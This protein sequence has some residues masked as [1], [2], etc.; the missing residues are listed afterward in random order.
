ML[1]ESKATLCKPSGSLLPVSLP[2]F[3]KH[4]GIAFGLCKDFVSNP[5][6]IL[7]D[8]WNLTQGNAPEACL[9]T[10]IEKF[11]KEYN[12]WSVIPNTGI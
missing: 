4:H 2:L 3:A 9:W 8:F 11:Q 5:P 12:L 6:L 10:K 1:S 7:C